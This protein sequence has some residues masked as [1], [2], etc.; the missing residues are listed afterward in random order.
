MLDDP[1]TPRRDGRTLAAAGSFPGRPEAAAALLA[2]LASADNTQ[3]TGQLMFAD[4]GFECR[5]MTPGG[6][7]MTMTATA[8]RFAGAWTWA[9]TNGPK[10]ALEIGVNFA[11]PYADLQRSRTTGWAT[12]AR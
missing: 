8:D 1:E 9:R 6:E 3:M 11:L 12:S 2:W 7:L 4:G 10:A 5:T